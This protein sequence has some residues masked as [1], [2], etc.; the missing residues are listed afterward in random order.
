ML[1][2]RRANVQAAELA[3]VFLGSIPVEKFRLFR[4]IYVASCYSR[5]TRSC[6]AC[7]LYYIYYVVLCVFACACETD[8]HTWSWKMYGCVLQCIK[9]RGRARGKW[10]RAKR[11][12]KE[13]YTNCENIIALCS[14]CTDNLPRNQF[15][16]K[17]SGYGCIYIYTRTHT[18]ARVYIYI[19]LAYMKIKSC[20]LFPFIHR[21][22]KLFFFRHRRGAGKP[23]STLRLR[24][25]SHSS[26]RVEN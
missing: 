11:R 1:R 20:F 17:T 7:I 19:Y 5:R 9:M 22:T 8:R 6:M 13:I 23:F 12:K 14:A 26:F 3:R 21:R 25:L 24:N 15:S 18:R 16:V 2:Q 10:T 4:G